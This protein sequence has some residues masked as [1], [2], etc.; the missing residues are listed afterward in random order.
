[1]QTGVVTGDRV[2]IVA[3]LKPGERFVLR[4]GF[5]LRDGDRVT[6]NGVE[7]GKKP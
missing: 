7:A 6:S 2:E 3:G 4:G 5:S 1:V